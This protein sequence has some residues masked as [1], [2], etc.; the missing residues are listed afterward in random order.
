MSSADDSSLESRRSIEVRLN[1]LIPRAKGGSNSALG[2]ALD[3]CRP[4]LL[5]AA[6]RRITP[7]LQPIT[8]PSDV[9]QDTFVNATRA[10]GFFRGSQPSEFLGWLRRILA[11]RI[12]EIGRRRAANSD[13]AAEGV[14]ATTFRR[15][16]TRLVADDG[17]P[18]SIAA[19]HE[20]ADL[21]RM[22]LL[23]LPDRHC[24]VLH[25]RFDEGLSFPQIGQRLELSEDAARM[26]FNRAVEG[27]RRELP[28]LAL[29]R[30]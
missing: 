14:G 15:N 2:R 24:K 7:H 11:N 12:L 18:S 26:L 13:L 16:D 8:S 6:R 28:P 17:S 1:D 4:Q 30:Y 19:N 10:I 9:V 3:V 5:G 29:D 27:L 20:I 22:A 21:I 25:L 23:R